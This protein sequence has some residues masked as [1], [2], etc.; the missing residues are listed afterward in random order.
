MTLFLRV[1]LN[2]CFFYIFTEIINEKCQ[3]DTNCRKVKFAKCSKNKVCIC[4]MNTV[5]L[6]PGLCYPLLNVA[7]QVDKDC[8]VDHSI[9]IENLCKCKPKYF[10][11]SVGN[12]TPSKLFYYLLIIIY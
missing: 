1:D 12:C 2:I 3:E 7:C 10:P 11:L 6:S 8:K 5:A 9:C 4:V